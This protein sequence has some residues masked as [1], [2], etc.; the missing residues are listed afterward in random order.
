MK[1][2]KDLEEL[3]QIL[4]S[5]RMKIKK[6]QA[7]NR[8]EEMKYEESPEGFDEDRIDEIIDL[9]S[10]MEEI[11]TDGYWNSLASFPH[12]DGKVDWRDPISFQKAYDRLK[13]RHEYEVQK[14]R[15]RKI[16]YHI[17]LQTIFLRAH[18]IARKAGIE[19]DPNVELH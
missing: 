9:S 18:T 5:K 13:M 3:F 8:G 11:L 4:H 19:D 1:V 10:Q 17:R 2:L 7:K 6:E 12:E 14:L 15:E 16:P